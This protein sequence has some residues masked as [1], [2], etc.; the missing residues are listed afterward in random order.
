M[1]YIIWF[2]PESN[3]SNS[4]IQICENPLESLVG[5]ER[6]IDSVTK[7]LSKPYFNKILKVLIKFNPA[8]A[9]I[10]VD[11]ILTEQTEINIKDSTKESKIKTLVWLSNFHNNKS[12]TD[13]TKGDILE[14]LNN[15]RKTTTEDPSN[16]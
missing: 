8:N 16:K 6:K 15:S 4:K 13:M 12:F 3:C 9:R 1:V 10:I 5:L 14:Y 7:T 2:K 11:Y